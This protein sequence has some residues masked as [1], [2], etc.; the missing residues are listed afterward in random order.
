MLP[1]WLYPI[2]FLMI[3]CLYRF[4]LVSVTQ[5][6]KENAM[7]PGSYNDIAEWYDRYIRERAVYS[8]VILP[9]VMELVGDVHNRTICDLACGQGYIAREMARR[10]AN[11]TGLDLAPKLLEIA[12]GYEAEAP[13][14]IRYLQ[15]DAQEA[16]VLDENSFTGCVC[17]M[18]LINIPDLKA[19]FQTVHRILE[20]N[21]W[22]CFVISHPC[23]DTPQAEWITLSNPEHPI[24][25][26]VTGYF[27]ER[28]WLSTRV[29]KE[30]AVGVR[31]RVGDYH[32]M[33]STY[34]NTLV[35]TGFAFERMEEPQALV[36]GKRAEQVPGNSQ[37]PTLLLIRAHAL[38]S[39]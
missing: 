33:L 22:F 5:V 34:L 15:G 16:S 38:K 27:D 14:G 30:G 26:V 2:S 39:S 9:G 3:Y 10:G 13:L 1:A 25:R 36:G 23:F 31:G 12:R 4:G 35:S 19:T 20:P 6:R 29:R 17:V 21:G 18:A 37:I 8:E 28:L 11:V 24:G 32:R 7:I